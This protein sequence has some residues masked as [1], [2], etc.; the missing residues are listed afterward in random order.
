M[1][2]LREH[3]QT[4]QRWQ[5]SYQ[6]TYEWLVAWPALARDLPLGADGQARVLSAPLRWISEAPYPARCSLS[7]P[8]ARPSAGVSSERDIIS[9]LG[10]DHILTPA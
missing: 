8:C 4:Q 9:P 3:F 2:S 5:L 10:A 7:S 6:D 1:I